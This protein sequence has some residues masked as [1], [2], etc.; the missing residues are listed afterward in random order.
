MKPLNFNFK[1]LALATML[2]GT[3]TFAQVG[4]GTTSPEGALDIQ[5]TKGGLVIPRVNLIS[6]LD[7]ST[8][9][10]M[11]GG[12]PV[13]GTI[14][15]DL[16]AN[17]TEGFYLFTGTRWENLLSSDSDTYLGSSDQTLTGDR[18]ITMS[19]NDLNF[20]VSATGSNGLR[21]NTNYLTLSLDNGNTGDAL[22]TSRGGMA[23]LIDNNDNNGNG[24]EYFSWGDDGAFGSGTGDSS[25]NEYMRLDN[26]G[27]GI[28]TTNPETALHV[29][30]T[31][32]NINVAKF[33]SDEFPMFAGFIIEDTGG[34]NTARFAI[35]PGNIA[36]N[37]SGA[38]SGVPSGNANGKNSVT[39]DVEGSTYDIY[40]FMEGTI[41]PGFDNLTSLRSP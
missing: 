10:D 23:F 38:L 19:G 4:I 26:S 14:I 11:K 39:F 16:G 27:L 15:Y 8:I 35:T 34:N 9:T 36:N 6:V 25:Y 12:N 2:I 20:D 5:S 18:E 7:V 33:Q 28:G 24:N 21:F 41:R 3:A 40:T 13:K 37:S 32:S 1:L 31:T 17:L 29:V 22:F 30:E